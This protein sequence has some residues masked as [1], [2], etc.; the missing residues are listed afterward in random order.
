MRICVLQP[1]Y[2]GSSSD[3]QHYDPPRDL[4]H[5]APGDVVHHEFLR[6][7]S[8]F[9]QI[10]A[11]DREG[12]DIYVNLCE[13]YRDSD[14]PSIDVIWALEHLGM[15]FTGPTSVLYD[16]P[17]DRMKLVAQSVEVAVPPWAVVDDVEEVAAAVGH[18]R[19]P[20][21]VKPVDYGDSMGIDEHALVSDAAEL[22][23]QVA[24]VV[25]D[26]G[27]ALIEEYIDGREFTVLV[28]GTPEPAAPPL[29]LTPLEFRFPRG[30][31]FKTY[32][33][34]VRQFH[35]E[36]NV[37]CRNATLAA[38]LRDAASRVFEGFA[39]DGYAR[40]DFRVPV[41]GRVV[42]LETNFT[43]SVFYPDGYQGSADYI[44]QYDGLGQAGFLR[45]IIA[46]GLARH[47]RRTQP[48][49]ADRDADQTDGAG[50]VA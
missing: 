27:K 26:Y 28:C 36:C 49:T 7:I 38:R 30:T 29:A 8:T 22:R 11:L 15:P 1:S 10:R 23:Q 24:A 20:L 9:G 3:Y 43:C 25:R 19:F 31:S 40:M 37:P 34:K 12:F 46:E 21:F 48:R 44:L 32:D 41:D 18:L 45:H 39:G 5:L 13:G 2:E 50:L 16:P 4:S 33:L 42:F 35:P 14:V 6:K 47:A 17:K